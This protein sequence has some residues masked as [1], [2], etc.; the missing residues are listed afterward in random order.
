M[1]AV[2]RHDVY[3]SGEDAVDVVMGREQDGRVKR[4]LMEVKIESQ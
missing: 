2:V 1:M 4:K 3:R